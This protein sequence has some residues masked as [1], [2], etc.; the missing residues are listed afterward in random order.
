MKESTTQ[1]IKGMYFAIGFS[2]MFV[3]LLYAYDIYRDY[4]SEQISIEFQKERN[5]F[6]SN[7]VIEP[8]LSKYY[9]QSI[10][11]LVK[12]ISKNSEPSFGHILEVELFNSEGKFLGQCFS[13][14]LNHIKAN[15]TENFEIICKEKWPGWYKEATKT[16]VRFFNG[17]ASKEYWIDIKH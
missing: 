6:E 1:I 9:N 2:L 7:I 10:V 17:I 14:D 15:A 4:K 13:S 16:S 11:V 5:A 8:L 3:P 12:L